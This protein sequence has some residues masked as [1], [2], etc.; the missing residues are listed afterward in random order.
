MREPQLART[1]VAYC[2]GCPNIN[3]KCGNWDV[4]LSIRHFLVIKGLNQVV[5][6]IKKFMD[7]VSGWFGA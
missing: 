1:G 2:D 5:M 4:G 3:R 7:K 6:F